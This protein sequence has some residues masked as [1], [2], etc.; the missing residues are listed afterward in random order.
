[1]TSTRVDPA[2]IRL[3]GIAAI[4]ARGVQRFRDSAEVP[5]EDPTVSQNLSDSLPEPLEIFA[6]SSLSVSHDVSV[7]VGRDEISIPS[8]P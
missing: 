5:V 6:D 1:M 4:L 3:R 8:N 7:P 2:T